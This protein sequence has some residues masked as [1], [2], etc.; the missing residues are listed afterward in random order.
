MDRCI[1]VHNIAAFGVLLTVLFT[2]TLFAQEEDSAKTSWLKIITNLN[3]FYTVIDGN[4]L[5]ATLM[6]PGDSLRVKPGNRK[7]SIVWKNINDFTFTEDISANTTFKKQITFASFP[8]KP[9][10]SYKVITG[11]PNLRIKTDLRSSIYLDGEFIGKHTVE[12]L[13]MTGNHKLVITHPKYGSLS[14]KINTK[15]YGNTSVVRYNK[16]PSNLS[17]AAQLIPGAAYTSKKQY[18]RAGITYGLLGT[19]TV[20]LI[21]QQSNYSKKH[22]TLM[23]LKQFYDNSQTTNKAINA[24]WKVENV[25]DELNKIAQRFNSYLLATGIVYLISTLDGIRK[26]KHG[27]KHSSYRK[28]TA[29]SISS[30]AIQGG[31]APL[32]NLE[33]SL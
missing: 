13:A 1:K 7:I 24:R 18:T 15:I 31:V 30:I 14:K 12:V 29:T 11:E 16:S 25:Q 33:I 20:A 6:K 28:K 32:F 27:Y 17:F 21:K 3:Q 5:E 4:Y 23:K 22:N 26:P 10:T 8:D 9:R 2:H 19:L